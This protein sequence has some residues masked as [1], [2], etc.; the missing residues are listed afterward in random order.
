[1]GGMEYP[2][3]LVCVFSYIKCFEIVDILIEC[4]NIKNST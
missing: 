4:V 3:Y 1:M 2:L